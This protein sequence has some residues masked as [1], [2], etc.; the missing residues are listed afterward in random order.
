MGKDG[1]AHLI[2]DGLNLAYEQ[3]DYINK[4]VTQAQAAR[5]QLTNLDITSYEI[6]NEPDLYSANGFRTGPWDGATYTEEWLDR[7]NAIWQQ[8]LEPNNIPSQ[9]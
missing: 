1:V 9:L 3:P 7:A 6:G 4:I 8:D 5:A 2:A